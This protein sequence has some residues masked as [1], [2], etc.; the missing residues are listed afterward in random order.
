M[1]P[2]K[3]CK[4]W[5]TIPSTSKLTKLK[6]INRTH[7]QNKHLNT[8][9][10]SIDAQGLARGHP[11]EEAPLGACQH[12][13]RTW[14]SRRPW[15]AAAACRPTE[16]TWRRSSSPPTES[17]AVEPSLWR[18]AS[19]AARIAGTRSGLHYTTPGRSSW[20]QRS[21]LFVCMPFFQRIWRTG[22]CFTI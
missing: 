15:A 20:I 14:A 2:P 4:I 3:C 9:K 5:I 8:T 16:S 6:T 17:T 22:V 19:A 10:I 21:P 1:Q 18:C 13:P 12:L 7:E 11:G